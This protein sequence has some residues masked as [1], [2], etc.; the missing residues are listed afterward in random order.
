MKQISALFLIALLSTGAH[1]DNYRD[2]VGRSEIRLHSKEGQD[3]IIISEKYQ[4]GIVADTQVN[5]AEQIVIVVSGSG[6]NSSTQGVRAVLI[7]N[8]ISADHGWSV[9]KPTIF[10]DLKAL[11]DGSSWEFSGNFQGSLLL[12]SAIHGGETINCQPQLSI[13]IDGNWQT[14][15]VNGTHNFHLNF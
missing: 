15:P 5:T 13:V 4:S 7:P 9:D 12:R 11:T 2:D 14:D 1:A 10:A 3:C 6:V 8:C